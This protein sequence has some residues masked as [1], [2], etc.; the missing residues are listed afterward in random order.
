[1]GLRGRLSNLPDPL[2]TL[3]KGSSA[4]KR[5]K[6]RERTTITRILDITTPNITTC[7]LLAA[8]GVTLVLGHQ[9]GLYLL[10]PALIAVLAGGVWNAW[11]ILVKLSE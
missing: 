1:M 4:K 11:V 7:L 6:G 2:E 9:R 5:K 3:L 8:V 10:V